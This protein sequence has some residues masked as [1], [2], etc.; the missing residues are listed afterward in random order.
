MIHSR[1][2]KN[3]LSLIK[4]Y[5]LSCPSCDMRRRNTNTL[6]FFFFYIPKHHHTSGN[7]VAL[8]FFSFSTNFDSY[9]WKG[10]R[11]KKKKGAR[12]CLG[13]AP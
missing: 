9:A 10:K 11:R 7:L 8:F 13:C 12:I 3:T 1:E 4:Q 6:G 5:T 2:S